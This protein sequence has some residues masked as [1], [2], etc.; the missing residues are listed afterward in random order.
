MVGIAVAFLGAAAAIL[1]AIGSSWLKQRNEARR[2]EVVAW[3]AALDEAKK[4]FNERMAGLKSSENSDVKEL[5]VRLAKVEREYIS[6]G[7]HAEF[8]AELLEAVKEIR[9]ELR[10]GFDGMGARVEK[11]VERI[12]KVEASQGK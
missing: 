10:I 6:R 4:N 5:E 9:S 1:V 2:A 12:V 8:R 7:D 3:G 11:L